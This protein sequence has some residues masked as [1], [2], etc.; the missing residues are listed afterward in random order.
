MVSF[1]INF[2]DIQFFCF[3]F[4]AESGVQN[5][6]VS[7]HPFEAMRPE[8]IRVLFFSKLRIGLLYCDHLVVVELQK[9]MKIF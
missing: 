7:P 8:N 3:F 2:D 5:M 4:G 1:D 9:V 6:T